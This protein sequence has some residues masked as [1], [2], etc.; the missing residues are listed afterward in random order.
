MRRDLGESAQEEVRP[1][2][3]NNLHGCLEL[4]DGCAR[5]TL[6]ADD[7]GLILVAFLTGLH[8]CVSGTKVF[9]AC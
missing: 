7:A 1:S 9:L 3:M 2:G 4:D 6:H 5:D 8:G